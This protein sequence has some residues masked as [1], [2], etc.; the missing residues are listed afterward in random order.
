MLC[1]YQER[2]EDDNNNFVV[3]VY[4]E[5]GMY[6]EIFFFIFV[7]WFFQV[8]FRTS[9]ITARSL[10]QKSLRRFGLI[11]QIRFFYSCLPPS[12]SCD[13]LTSAS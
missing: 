6:Q 5:N 10:E 7:S 12:F 4:M 1:R 8:P 13:C 11:G 9:L 2:F 3:M